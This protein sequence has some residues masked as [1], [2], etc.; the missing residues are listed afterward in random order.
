MLAIDLKK[1]LIKLKMG[2]NLAV[3]LLIL[4]SVLMISACQST[5]DQVIEPYGEDN[6]I[7]INDNMTEQTFDQTAMPEVGEQILVM[8]TSMGVIKA[9]LFPDLVPETHKNF[10]F[11]VEEDNYDGTIFHRVIN[12][13]MVQGGDIEGLNGMGGYSYKGPGTKIAE[14]TPQELAHV[15]GALSMAKTMMPATTGSQFF[16]VQAVGGTPHL[17]G[18]HSVFGQVFEGMD[19]VDAIAAV[20]TAAQDKPAEDVVLE[21][22]YLTE[23]EG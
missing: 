18:Q 10:V 15:R 9:R 14:E 13:F 22:V 11:H 6:T 4:V 2:K 1:Y 21:D 16:I 23:Y 8:E 3:S 5:N 20:E 17:D 7:N 12:G 19:V